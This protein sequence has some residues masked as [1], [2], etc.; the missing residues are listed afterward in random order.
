MSGKNDCPR[1]R[2]E[3]LRNKKT[4][5]KV[6]WLHR[7]WEYLWADM[8]H[9]GFLFVADGVDGTEWQGRHMFKSGIQTMG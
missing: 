2:Q 5:S 8:Q 1:P 9:W 7:R 4:S 6:N 3:V